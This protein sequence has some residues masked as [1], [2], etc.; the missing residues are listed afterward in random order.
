[1]IPDS[2]KQDLLNRVDIVDVIERYVP[3]KKAGSNFSACCPFHTE[4][5]PSFTVS[6]TKQFYHCFGCGA[7]GNAI[8]FVMEYQGLGY[9]DAVRALAEG[10]GMQ[11]PEFEPRQKKPQEGPDLYDILERASQYYRQQLKASP[12]AIE[13]LKRRG[14]S[15]QIAAKF[16]IGY[17]PDGWQNLQSEF[18]DYADKALKD[19]GLVIDNDE[20]RRYDRFRDRV[21][22]P[23]LN[24]RGAVIGFG[25][26]VIGEGEPKYLNSPETPLFE[27]GRELYGLSQARLPIREAG[28]AIV[29]E[30]YMDVVALAQHGIGYAVAT[31]GTATSPVHIGKLLRQTDEVVFSFDG[32]AAGRRAAW[33]A[34]EVSLPLLA[35]QKIV[36]FLFLP[37]EDDPDSFVRAHGRE[38]FEARLREARPLSEFLLAELKGRVDMDTVEGRA[39]LIH[40]ARPLLQKLAAPVMQLQLLKQLAELSGMT[41]D[42]ASRLCGIRAESRPDLR[43]RTAASAGPAWSQGGAART[44][45]FAAR[46]PIGRST[47]RDKAVLMAGRRRERDFLRYVLMVPRLAE[48]VPDEVLAGDATE[49]KALAAVRSL[50]ESHGIANT[51]QLVELLCDGP[52]HDVVSEFFGEILTNPIPEA[53]VEVA[54]GH[55]LLYVEE[56]RLSARIEALMEKDRSAG[57]DGSTGLNSE[58]R[59]QLMQLLQEQR[60]L[61]EIRA[62]RPAV[63]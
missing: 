58:E 42:E 44:A 43:A 5:T 22:F 19:A 46:D 60:K 39:R 28:R 53:D 3:L 27:K 32:D 11:L 18:A 50:V 37:P 51:A 17:A 62:A 13:Y 45:A 30:G 26:R 63:I 49:A 31:L 52:H 12:K 61:K 56:Q 34:L 6:P 47:H 35:D 15:G 24:Q 2:F 1:M 57:A 55:A 41:Q 10:A 25:G 59:G 9:V 20:G 7:N 21:M 14:L 33:H 38:V 4:K 23:I 16:G 48:K 36:R 8:S 29:V 54:F 40:E